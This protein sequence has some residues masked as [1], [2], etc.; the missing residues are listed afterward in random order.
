MRKTEIEQDNP[1]F[2]PLKDKTQ[3]LLRRPDL[4]WNN[5]ETEKRCNYVGKCALQ[6]VFGVN[7]ILYVKRGYEL[8]RWGNGI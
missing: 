7:C 4:Y 6:N 2:Q 8:K 5:T 1:Y 3:N